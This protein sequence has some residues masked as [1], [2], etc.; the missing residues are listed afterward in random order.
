MKLFSL[1]KQ[2]LA[3][4]LGT[5]NTVIIQEGEVVVD[6]PSIV[7]YNRKTEETIIQ[8][9]LEEREEYGFS[10]IA[11]SHSP[12]FLS[13]ADR[14]F[15][16]GGGQVTEESPVK[17]RNNKAK[18][19][20]NTTRKTT[21]QLGEKNTAKVKASTKPKG[22]TKAKTKSKPV[23]KTKGKTKTQKTSGENT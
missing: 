12:H 19:K 2:E 6:E 16:V 5:A 8:L 14:V 11:A 18:T 23:T 17:P 1:F 9:L 10:I 21:T 4:D 7:A 15:Q 13:Y 3:I 20:K 22:R